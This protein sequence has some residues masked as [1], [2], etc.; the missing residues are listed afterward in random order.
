[1][2]L[3]KFCTLVEE[4]IKDKEKYLEYFEENKD[5]LLKKDKS[6]PLLLKIYKKIDI[7][8]FFIILELGFIYDFIV[9]STKMSFLQTLIINEE[10]DKATKLVALKEFKDINYIEKES[11]QTA[12]MMAGY[13]NCAKLGQAL[14]FKGSDPTL[15]DKNGLTALQIVKLNKN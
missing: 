12:L 5:L 13:M 4:N 2:E 6:S 1:M 15:R 11:K 9:P 7:S 10:M 3:L 14:L 8:T